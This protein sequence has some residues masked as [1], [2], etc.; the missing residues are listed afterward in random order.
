MTPSLSVVTADLD[1][2]IAGEVAEA[3]LAQ[4]AEL[5]V[6]VE[7][8][9]VGRDAPGALASFRAADSFHFLET[10]RPVWPARAR[11]LAIERARGELV[12]SLDADC[13]PEPGWLAALLAAH[14][15]P[16]RYVIGGSLRVDAE[17]PA[18]ADNVS[19]FHAYL[20]HR[21]PSRRAVLPAC[22]FSVRRSAFAEVGPFDETLELS[23]DVDWMLR[24]RRA[25]YALL[26]RPE[27]RA[28]HRSQRNT[29]EA[30]L[31]KAERT[32]YCS[33]AVRRR[34]G[35]GL[36]RS[37][38]PVAFR[39]A[40]PLLAFGAAA[41]ACGRARAW[42]RAGTASLVLSAKLAWCRGARRRLFEERAARPRH[43]TLFVT[44]RCNARCGHCFNAE[45]LNRGA[46]LLPA[47]RLSEL[48]REVGGAPTVSLSG[49]EPFL[50]GALGALVGSLGSHGARQVFLPT[51]GLLPERTRD[52][53]EALL[54]LPRGP[55]IV[56]SL[57]IDGLE[58]THDRIRAVPGGFQR[59]LETY[60]ALARLKETPGGARLTLRAGTVLCNANVA[61]LP[62]LAEWVRR[63]MPA[64]DFHNFEILRGRPPDGSLSAPTADELQRAKPQIFAA[65]ERGAFFGRGR[66]LRSW[67]ALILKRYLF[68]LHLETL[69]QRRQLIPCLAGRATAVVN[70]EGGLS[71]CELRETIGNLRSSSLA[72]LWSSP[73]AQEVR[74]SIERG[75]CHCVQSCFQ[76]INVVR[77]PRV[78]PRVAW[79]AVTGRFGASQSVSATRNPTLGSRVSGG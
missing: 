54:G 71:F 58:A 77:S 16:G 30:V 19:S 78:W 14:R 62:A 67:G 60:R 61:E 46:A 39:L 13:V 38:G 12:A 35:K 51:N 44:D 18:F 63:E 23:E 24:A 37:A 75:E 9:V 6:P 53:V 28:W 69:R 57:S 31:A 50:F 8:L 79:Y 10:P 1:G 4:A 15:C 52:E 65:W 40:S 41:L 36:A 70:D 47:A 3:V 72:E 25:G 55:R 49:G 11:N 42:R 73:R 26:F 27:V 21:R 20:P 66:R 2:P 76:Q 32:G 29:A 48:A 43:L 5:A 33:M 22:N 17:G 45:A 59:L 34:H 64:V 68:E 74:A 7:V 56:V